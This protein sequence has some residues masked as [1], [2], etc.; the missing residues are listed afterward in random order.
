VSKQERN[1][2][3][4]ELLRNRLTFGQTATCEEIAAWSDCSTDSV[5]EMERKALA[6]LRKL[7]GRNPELVPARRVT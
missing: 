6:K 3:G 2:L 4:V 7:V 5:K 1:D